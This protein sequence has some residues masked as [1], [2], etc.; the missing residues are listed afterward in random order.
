[1]SATGGE[2]TLARAGLTLESVHTRSDE[3]DAGRG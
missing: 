2:R 1:M 3:Y